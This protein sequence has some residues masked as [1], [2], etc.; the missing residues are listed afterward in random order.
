VYDA[1]LSADL[2]RQHDYTAICL[3]EEARWIGEPPEPGP[4]ATGTQLA[5]L[6]YWQ[7]I[8]QSGWVAPS[9]L[10][11]RQREFFRSRNYSGHRPGRPPLLIRHLERVRGVPYPQVVA[12]IAALLARP[13]L[14]EM[15][16]TVL[17]DC[18]GVGVAISDYC[19]QAG[20]GHVAIT[21]T[22]GD[23]VNVQDGG[24]TI[25]APK[26]ELVA[27]GQVA[28]AEGRIRIASG[29]PLAPILV[30]ELSDYRV[31][32]S[33]SGHDSYSAREN[34]HDDLVYALCQM[35]WY[36]DWYSQHWDDALAKVNR[37]QEA[38]R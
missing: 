13:P 31:T 26:R 36:R 34:E 9:A 22:G 11:P 1:Y 19:W 10:S 8:E 28:L 2:G 14:S 32:I 35:A 7:G 6:T 20:I 23:A 33:A 21:A 15:S 12:Q 37:R 16:A 18:G 25:H 4:F 3:G 5:E 24:R 27:A 17:L 30:K 29:L 38:L